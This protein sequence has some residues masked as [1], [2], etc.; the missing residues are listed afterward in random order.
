MGSSERST[1]CRNDSIWISGIV[2]M[3]YFPL[4]L[5]PVWSTMNRL[6]NWCFRISMRSSSEHFTKMV[7]AINVLLIVLTEPFRSTRV[8]FCT[9]TNT[10]CPRLRISLAYFFSVRLPTIATYQDF[11][12]FMHTPP[13]SSV[14]GTVVSVS[15]SVTGSFILSPIREILSSKVLYG[16]EQLAYNNQILNPVL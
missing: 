9:G 3:G 13:A 4:H 1:N 11:L 10:S 12:L 7:A 6:A 8:S 15:V 14:F 16:R 2:A 5:I